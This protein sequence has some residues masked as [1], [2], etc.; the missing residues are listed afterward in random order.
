MYVIIFDPFLII[1]IVPVTTFPFPFLQGFE[2]K[3]KKVQKGLEL[4][5]RRQNG[6]ALPGLKFPK[7]NETRIDRTREREKRER[8]KGKKAGKEN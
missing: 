3:P 4:E 6:N 5:E 7:S 8:K 1:F 2:G